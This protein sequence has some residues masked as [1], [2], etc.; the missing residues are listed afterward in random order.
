MGGTGATE[1]PEC[2]NGHHNRAGMAY[3][4][5]CGIAL[6]ASTGTTEVATESEPATMGR[7]AAVPMV[8]VGVLALVVIAGGAFALGRQSDDEPPS[9]AVP[10][11]TTTAPAPTSTEAPTTSTT[12]T[13]PPTTAAVPS[14]DEAEAARSAAVVYF[15]YGVTAEGYPPF[16][17]IISPSAAPSVESMIIGPDY[18]NAGCTQIVES[19]EEDPIPSP[20]A[21]GW[22]LSLRYRCPDGPPISMATG[23]PLP[24]TEDLYVEV[25]VAPAPTGGYWATEVLN[26]DLD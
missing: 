18:R 17:E 5:T 16:E 1:G 14:L 20:P 21:Y 11:T 7:K 25:T 15:T 22:V 2:P 23:D 6:R 26:V 4:T 13:P 10:S 8:L 19:I 9:A 24:M 12:T 3:C